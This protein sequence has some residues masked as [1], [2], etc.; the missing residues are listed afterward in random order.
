MAFREKAT[1]L[2]MFFFSRSVFVGG[3][4]RCCDCYSR[5]RPICN[6]GATQPDL[7]LAPAI[8]A[9]DVQPQVVA[10]HLIQAMKNIPNH[11]IWHAPL[12]E[13]APPGI[14]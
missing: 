13:H 10:S 14:S 2:P 3:V 9:G 8:T 12:N 6:H 7:F 1:I 11:S 4:R 5:T